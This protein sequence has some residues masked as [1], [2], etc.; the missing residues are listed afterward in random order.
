MNII[1]SCKSKSPVSAYMSSPTPFHPFSNRNYLPPQL[2]PCY[3]SVWRVENAYTMLA[4][5]CFN[6]ASYLSPVFNF[7]LNFTVILLLP[8]LQPFIITSQVPPNAV[9]L[10]GFPRFLLQVS[11]TLIT[12][13][14]SSKTIIST[15]IMEVPKPIDTY[16]TLLMV[17]IISIVS[18]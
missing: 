18:S 1:I 15:F 17:I 7:L 3:F 8:T 6:T 2:G 13:F 9:S 11:L 12:E 14:F 10:D 16:P 4:G 5:P